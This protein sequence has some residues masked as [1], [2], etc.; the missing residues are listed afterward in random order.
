MN[1]IIVPQGIG[2]FVISFEHISMPWLTRMKCA[3]V[4]ESEVC[5]GWREWSVSWLTRVEYVVEKR[6]NVKS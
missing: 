3:L 2:D 5:L 4:D 1:L 6:Q